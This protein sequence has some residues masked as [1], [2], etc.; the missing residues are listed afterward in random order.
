M[1]ENRGSICNF[2]QSGIR[3]D[4][5]ATNNGF[6]RTHFLISS[7][8]TRLQHLDQELSLSIVALVMTIQRRRSGDRSAQEI[9]DKLC[10]Q[11]P[12]LIELIDEIEQQFDSL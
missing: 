5:L 2:N 4:E 3:C 11:H 8:Q 9:I 12:I 6:C 7:L 1:A 10:R